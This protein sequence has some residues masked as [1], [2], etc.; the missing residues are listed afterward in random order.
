LTRTEPAPTF[1]TA[2]KRL[3]EIVQALE[4]GEL[5]LDESLR[6]Y[7]EGIELSRLCHAK[8]EEAEVKIAL[9]LKDARGEPILDAQGLP[10]TVPFRPEGADE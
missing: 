9:L 2:L 8:L 4:K 7:E 10:K 6:L 3:E 1:E 5:A